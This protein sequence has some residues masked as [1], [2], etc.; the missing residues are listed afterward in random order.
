[1]REIKRSVHSKWRWQDTIVFAL[2]YRQENI[3]K[4]TCRYSADTQKA[5]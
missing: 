1:M 4:I 3:W 2:K 5:M